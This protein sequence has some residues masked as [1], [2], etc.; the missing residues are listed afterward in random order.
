[1]GDGLFAENF[2]LPHRAETRHEEFPRET[3]ARGALSAPLA[4]REIQP[5]PPPK[6]PRHGL[7]HHRA[8]RAGSGG[9]GEI[10]YREQFGGGGVSD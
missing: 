8:R 7:R 2:N 3:F 9:E 5:P 4:E 1:M 6:L 10:G